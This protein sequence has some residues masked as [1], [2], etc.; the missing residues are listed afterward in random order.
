MDRRCL[1]VLMMIGRSGYAAR[2]RRMTV[3]V[4]EDVGSVWSLSR[5]VP[6]LQ[7]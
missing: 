6:A 4:G 5:S 1:P 7:C 3:Y 2:I